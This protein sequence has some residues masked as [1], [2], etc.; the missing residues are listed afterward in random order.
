VALTIG[1]RLGAYQILATIGAGG[2]GEVYRA[3]D[4]R[5][6]RD[7]ALKVLPKLFALD[8]DR[9]AR[10]KRE[11]QVLASLNHPNIASIYGFEESDGVQ[12]LV[13]ELV[14]G[15]TLADRV[16][17]GP[18][19]V[20]EALPMARQIAEALEAAHEQGII[21]RDLKPANISVRPDGTVKVL[22]FG[23]AKALQPVA[24]MRDDATDSPTVTSP[25]A[26]QTGV[27]LG[28][29]AYMSP[30]QVKGRQVDKRS[31]VWAFGAV[32]YEMLS[33]RGAFKGEGMSDTLAAVLRQDVDGTALPASTPASVRRLITRCLDRDVR[34]R[35][36]DIGE[37][38]I[39]L[40]DPVRSSPD[41]QS[42]AVFAPRP[43]WRLAMPV[44]IAAVVAGTLTGAVA[45]YVAHK[46]LP[47][48]TGTRLSVALPRFSPVTNFAGVEA[49]PSLSPDGR[50]VAFVSNRGGQWD[51][52]VSLVSGGNLIQITN[53]PNVETGPHWSP[54]GTR[55]VFARLNEDALTD[56]WVAPAFGG[57]ARR[58]VLNAATPA[59]SRDGKSIA[60]R[61]QVDEA[62]WLA[63]ADG[64][65][66]RHVT[67][68]EASAVRHSQPAFSPDGRSLVFVRQ[69][70]SQRS[71]L[72]VVDLEAGAIRDLTR[73]A[74]LALSPRWSPDGRFVYFSSSRGGTL[75]IWKI[76]VASAEIEPITAGQDDNEELDLSAD[77]T[78][79]VFSS[80]RT[81]IGL[82]EVS[83][84]SKSRGR[85]TWLTAGSARGETAPQYSPDGRRIA[86]FCNRNG[87]EQDTL[88]IM[89]ADGGNA[90]RLV[91]DGRFNI[92]P[93]WARDGQELVFVS[94]AAGQ[95]T[96]LGPNELR[97]ILLSGGAPQQL[98]MT[99]SDTTWGDIGPDGR[100]IYRTS[101]QTGEIYDPRTNQRHQVQNLGANPRWSPDGRA[102]AFAV[103]ASA[104][105]KANG[106]V[107]T[108]TTDGARRQVFAGWVVWFA[109]DRAGNILVLEGRP[110]LKGLLWRIE[111]GGRRSIV[112]SVPLLLR[113]AELS[114]VRFD[115]HPD[116]RRIVI[117]AR[118]VFESDIGLIDNVR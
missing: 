101:A 61:S 25:A 66:P 117:E 95:P 26:T 84:D 79:L 38:R 89:D 91:D 75:S 37:A 35:L 39:V 22:D 80:A 52:Y 86:Y 21:H 100:L 9:L 27:I 5:L 82:A 18:I 87:L 29:A 43:L 108:V 13:L 24:V 69:I 85:V 93:R 56:V 72:A 62:L 71:E 42:T 44:L 34:R 65:S 116:G 11:A 46:S 111:G 3:R 31:D 88:W 17:R 55:L 103:S 19:P 92:H 78:R 104:Q 47:S 59:W 109:F 41:A 30:E 40:E 76:A 8:P 14:E 96:R 114:P 49:Q 10:F 110:D 67:Q 54:D 32:L 64:A 45:W 99:P 112:A 94:R 57:R 90:S 28:T 36:R 83:L 102:F 53:D 33:G 50:S 63:E 81:N 107:W 1:S 20:D 73:D 7:V 105:P 6:N 70:S 97:R 74:A 118:P 60:Y 51:I 15:P 113:H 16:A 77:G 12:A 68:L 48:P 98:T 115:V 2:M 23:L 106:G 4:T 58:I